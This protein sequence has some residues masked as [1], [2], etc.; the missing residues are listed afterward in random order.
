M[1]NREYLCVC[2][3]LVATAI[4]QAI[5]QG[6]GHSDAG[7]SG[8]S[9]KAQE[10]ADDVFSQIWPNLPPNQ[11]R[12]SVARGKLLFRSNCGFCHGPDATGGN[13]GPDLVRSVLVNHDEHGD[14]IGPVIRGA[15]LDKGMPKFS[16]TKA[17][18]SDVVAFLHQRNRDARLRF[19]YKV[20]NVAVGS[21]VAGKAYFEG[22]CSNCHSPSGDLAGIAVRYPGDALQQRW[23]NPEPK[24]FGGTT[25]TPSVEVSVTLTN[26]QEY[27]GRLEHLDGF[28]VSLYDTQGDYHSF[29]LTSGIR[30]QVKDPLDPHR[31]LVNQ[32]TDGDMHDVTTYLE[33][34]K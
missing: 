28:N 31:K 19:T 32:L 27:S 15:A 4:P 26:G 18:I 13:S 33:S 34:L 29:A 6:T 1:L 17:Q 23:I 7:H 22:H 5:A 2:M 11:N 14:L 21:V 12:A 9:G 8:V 3:L 30:I 24:L 16:L 10:S 20:A 25:Q